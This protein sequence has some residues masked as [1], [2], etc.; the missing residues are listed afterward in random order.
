[1]VAADRVTADYPLV[2]VAQRAKADAVSPRAWCPRIGCQQSLNRIGFTR[3]PSVQDER[4]LA[5]VAIRPRRVDC[6]SILES[7]IARAAGQPGPL[8]YRNR[9]T[10]IGGNQA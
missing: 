7:L 8:D 4:L 6:F 10:R 9:E 1:L 2:A 3:R 5:E